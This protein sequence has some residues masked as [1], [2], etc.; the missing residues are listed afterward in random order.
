MLPLVGGLLG[1]FG[2]KIRQP[3]PHTDLELFYIKQVGVL[4]Q[5]LHIAHN[6]GGA[7]PQAFNQMLSLFSDQA[8]QTFLDEK[9]RARN[10]R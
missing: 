6:A 2:M 5:S 9:E 3:I 7:N 10:Q 8:R 1:L 4:Q